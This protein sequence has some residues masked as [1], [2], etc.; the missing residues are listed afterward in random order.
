VP[1]NQ[2]LFLASSAQVQYASAFAPEEHSGNRVPFYTTFKR[3]T[4]YSIELQLIN[5]PSKNRQKMPHF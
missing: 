4:S 3:S 5:P 2:G 1:F